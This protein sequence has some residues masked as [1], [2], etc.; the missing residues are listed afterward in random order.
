MKAI[1]LFACG[2]VGDL[3]MRAAGMEVLVANEIDKSRAEIF[4]T[5][6]PESEMI[7]G[8]VW[9][10]TDLIVKTALHKN[11][12]LPLDIVL[13]TPPC[14][15][16]SKNGRGKLLSLIRNGERPEIDQRNRLII[17]TIDI[18]KKSGAHTLIMENVPE[19]ASTFISNPKIDG[20]LINIIDY[21][22]EELGAE[23]YYDIKVVDF[24]NYGVPQNRSRLISVFTK[25]DS[26]KKEISEK[27]TIFPEETHDRDGLL[28]KK[29][30]SVRDSI[31]H[32]PPLDAK[33]KITSK[34]EDIPYHRVPTLDENKYLWVSNTPALK[35]AFDNQCMNPDCLFSENPVHG[36]KSNENGINR[37]NS[38][39]P[40]RCI[41]CNSI[42][43]RPWVFDGNDYRIMK[44]YTSAYKRMDW[45]K[46]SGTLTLNLSYACSDKKIHPS[47]NRVL[48][49][50]EAMILHTIDKYEFSLLRADGKKVSDKLVRELIGES[51]PPY[52]MQVIAEYIFSK[53]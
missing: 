50:Y 11:N 20:E 14:Q 36:S 12:Y 3:G 2:G 47:Q 15:G 40:I 22:K 52:G 30:V 16:M 1:S 10:H 49:L 6:Y 51:I 31:S 5:N 27:G 37:S 42:L 41:K 34:C 53:M 13:A 48:S 25:K 29:W 8:D 7:V 28:K 43:P 4:K 9:E 33:N 44:G 32:T 23:F 24:A 26:L 18:F 19:M 35:S 39:T 38:D 46:P 17:P 45:D 21:I